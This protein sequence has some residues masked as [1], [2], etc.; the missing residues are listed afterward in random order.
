M[1]NELG[2]FLAFLLLFICYLISKNDIK[3]WKTLSP[4]DKFG[5]IRAPFIGIIGIIILI[6]KI[7]NEW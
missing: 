7:I 3:N 1:S 4:L 6:L 5:V 2:L